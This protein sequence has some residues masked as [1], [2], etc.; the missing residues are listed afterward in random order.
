MDGECKSSLSR[1][2][3]HGRIISHAWTEYSTV[4]FA[5]KPLYSN[6]TLP[7]RHSL[8]CL[9]PVIACHPLLV[10]LPTTHLCNVFDGVIIDIVYYQSCS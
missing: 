4:V 7:A 1:L 10:Q 6:T 9:A 2:Q 3:I 8:R 5:E